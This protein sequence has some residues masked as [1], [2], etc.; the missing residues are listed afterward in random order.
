M[1]EGRGDGG[2]G[3]VMEGGGVV[4]E[5]GGGVMEGGRVVVEGGEGCGVPSDGLHQFVCQL[6][7]T[8]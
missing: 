6:P 2:G 5:G 8:D 1:E 4:M 3:G 7:P